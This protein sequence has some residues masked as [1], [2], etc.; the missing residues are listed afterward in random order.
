MTVVNPQTGARA[1]EV[2]R[3]T[4]EVIDRPSRKKPPVGPM[5]TTRP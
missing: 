1:A 5:L 3:C 4:T 2:A